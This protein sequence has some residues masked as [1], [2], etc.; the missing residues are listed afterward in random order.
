MDLHTLSGAV[1]TGIVIG[2]YVNQI[3]R[4]A[5]TRRADG[6]SIPSYLL[7]AA[8]SAL[9]LVHAR[10]IGSAVF[11]VLTIFQFVAC[12]LIAALASWFREPSQGR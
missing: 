6:V 11:T 12:L 4:L 8:A 5:R 9:L 2:G 7:W 1:G 10:G 3:A